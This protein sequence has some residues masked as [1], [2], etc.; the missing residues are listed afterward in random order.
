MLPETKSLSLHTIRDAA[1]FDLGLIVDS[2]F[3]QATMVLQADNGLLELDE[4]DT[5]LDLVCE[6]DATQGVLAASC[7][8]TFCG[9][10]EPDYSFITFRTSAAEVKKDLTGFLTSIAVKAPG[11]YA[12]EGYEYSWLPLDAQR[13]TDLAN[14]HLVADDAERVF[15]PAS[16]TGRL[17]ADHLHHAGRYSVVFE[18]DSNDA[19]GAEAFAE[20]H[21]VLCASEMPEAL[22][23]IRTARPT[24]AQYRQV[25]P[26]VAPSRTS[27]LLVV[28]GDE[29]AIVDGIIGQILAVLSPRARLRLLRLTGRQHLGLLQASCLPVYGWQNQK[30]FT[31]T[32]K[33]GVAA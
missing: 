18:I 30:T 27:S 19:A 14:A 11:L 17:H 33:A 8:S 7:V 13:V 5:W 10:D 29:L 31:R 22:R 32:A 23:L 26:D 16:M 2:Q 1:G 15:P 28:T 20:V 9:G 21:A 12:P 3:H 24:H 25:H 4:K 6:A